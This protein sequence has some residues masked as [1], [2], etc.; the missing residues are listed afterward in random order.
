VA[1]SVL[2][3][4]RVLVEIGIATVFACVASTG[5]EQGGQASWGKDGVGVAA[6]HPRKALGKTAQM[7]N[8]FFISEFLLVGNRN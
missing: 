3:G 8:A 7:A 6:Y 5:V 2:F 4:R 1:V